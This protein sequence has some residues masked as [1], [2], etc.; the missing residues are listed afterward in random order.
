MAVRHGD[1]QIASCVESAGIFD[2]QEQT[3]EPNLAWLLQDATTRLPGKGERCLI[4]DRVSLNEAARI[5]GVS[6]NTI[7]HGW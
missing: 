5:C 3:M 6:S 7:P 2:W 4:L 1:D